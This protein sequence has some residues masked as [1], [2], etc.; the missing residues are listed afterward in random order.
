[1]LNIAEFAPIPAA[2]T[3][4]AIALKPEFRPDIRAPNRKS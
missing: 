2:S 1:M 4:T 3:T